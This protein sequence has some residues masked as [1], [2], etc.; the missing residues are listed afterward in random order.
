LNERSGRQA[1]LFLT[2]P[3]RCPLVDAQLSARIEAA[4]N[5]GDSA[6]FIVIEARS[7]PAFYVAPE[8]EGIAGRFEDSGFY[9]ARGESRKLR[10]SPASSRGQAEAGAAPR[11]PRTLTATELEKRLSILDLRGSYE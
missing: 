4:E 10:F 1:I 6:I 5:E 9:L 8:F 7:A 2:E 11:D 3:K